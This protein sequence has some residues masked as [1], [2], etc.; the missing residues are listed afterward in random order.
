MSIDSHIDQLSGTI[1]R[2]VKGKIS[3]A[4]ISDALQSSFRMPDF[5][6]DMPV[7]WNL[8]AA[9]I[10]L[11]SATEMKQVIRL[12]MAAGSLRGSHYPLALVADSDINFGIA[13]MFQ[14]YAFELPLQ[15][16][17]F[18]DM[19]SAKNWIA[20]S[21]CLQTETS[22]ALENRVIHPYPAWI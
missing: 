3:T 6:P 14:G 8:H 20:S 15:I 9:D 4:E 21:P 22:T 2:T 11:M 1:V 17:V 13:K 10:S 18:R 16:G 5:R 7:I 19:G 12:I